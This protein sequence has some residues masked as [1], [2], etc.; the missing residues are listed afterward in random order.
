MI[1]WIKRHYNIIGCIALAIG[2]LLMLG[3]AGQTISEQ[4]Y[5]A[6]ESGIEVYNLIH[7]DLAIMATI[8]LICTVGGALLIYYHFKRKKHDTE[9][10]SKVLNTIKK[11]K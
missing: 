1:T 6:S 8:A 11:G 9:E 4:G 7:I 10:F 5:N 2:V 3:L